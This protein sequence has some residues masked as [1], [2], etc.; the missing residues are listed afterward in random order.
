MKYIPHQEMRNFRYGRDSE[1]QNVDEGARC[2]L[3]ALGDHENFPIMAKSFECVSNFPQAI[4]V[5][6]VPSD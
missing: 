1:I 2:R 4:F 6:Y 5:D 3:V